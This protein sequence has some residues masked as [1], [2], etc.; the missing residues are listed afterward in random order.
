MEII[1]YDE[2]NVKSEDI[3]SHIFKNKPNKRVTDDI[4]K[5]ADFAYKIGI[6]ALSLKSVVEIFNIQDIN[7]ETL[8]INNKYTLDS[9]NLTIGPK[10]GYLAPASEIVVVLS[11]VGQQIIELMKQRE[12]IGDY[13]TMYC[14]NALGVLSLNELLTNVSNHIS[15]YASENGW[16]RGPKMQPGSV[17]GWPTEKQR[18]LYK[19]AHGEK[20]GLTINESACLSPGIS[21][22]AL[23]GIGQDYIS[24]K[25]KSMC[26]ECPRYNKCLWKDIN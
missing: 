24:N 23:F 11:T 5:S 16:G 25:T 13:M 20:I 17:L 10:I 15:I 21:D 19:L 6:P 18:D 7:N 3:I 22:S 26:H 14:L 8:I 1:T 4:I 9:Y 2:I 12:T